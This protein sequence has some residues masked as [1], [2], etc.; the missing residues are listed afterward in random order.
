VKIIR[1]FLF[2]F[3]LVLSYIIGTSITVVISIFDTPSNR[4]KK[5]QRSAHIWAKFLVFL[6]GIP[7]KVYGSENIPK[8]EPL[9]FASNHQGAADI[10]IL[11]ACLPRGFTFI[12]KQEL[13][14]IPIFGWYL[15]QA[16]YIAVDRG[17]K[18][19]AV[20]F[21]VEAVKRLKEGGSILIFPEGTRSPDGKLHEFKRGSLLLAFKAK[22]RIVPI[23]I[24]GSF[25]IMPKKSRLINPVPV[26]V[27][28]G[29]PISIDK[30]NNDSELA[31]EDLHKTI[32]QMLQTCEP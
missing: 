2:Y 19:G 22:V 6:S 23:A 14:K 16:G 29:K 25:G 26:K 4:A 5:F 1:T 13:F 7:L 28:I 17:T 10:L 18:R 31:N 11:L 27:Q 20:D 15:R 32:K 8:N 24:S 9:I 12:I 30:Y 21:F 3:V